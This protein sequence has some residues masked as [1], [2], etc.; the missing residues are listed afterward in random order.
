MSDNRVY[1][2]IYTLNYV[3]KEEHHFT[4]CNWVR[5]LL[6]TCTM[7]ESQVL[8]NLMSVSCF[9][10]GERLWPNPPRFLNT[11][12]D[13]IRLQQLGHVT[14]PIILELVEKQVFSLVSIGDKFILKSLSGFPLDFE[15]F[16][17]HFFVC[18]PV[19]HK[20]NKPV[21]LEWTSV[22]SVKR[23]GETLLKFSHCLIVLNNIKTCDSGQLN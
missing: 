17:C 12:A 4:I 20:K 2:I 21:V 16:C 22:I 18:V 11:I 23:N 5:A 8:Y 1:L 13:G 10:T 7:I 19:F 9:I 3:N 14:W 6:S 15:C